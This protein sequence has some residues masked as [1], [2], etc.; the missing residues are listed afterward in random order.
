MQSLELENK[1]ARNVLTF[2]YYF[3]YFGLTIWTARQVYF[4]AVAIRLQSLE[5]NS[6]SRINE[7]YA[8]VSQEKHF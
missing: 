2:K 4:E 5:I 3:L 8:A 6:M 7:P 1:K